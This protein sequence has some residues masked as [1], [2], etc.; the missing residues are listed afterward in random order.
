[1]WPGKKPLALLLSLVAWALILIGAVRLATYDLG[2]TY[3]LLSGGIKPG[4]FYAEEVVPS[5]GGAVFGTLVSFAILLAGVLV[6][7]VSQRHLAKG[8]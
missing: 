2:L 5:T 4:D 6:R 3:E 7:Y 8:A 1:M